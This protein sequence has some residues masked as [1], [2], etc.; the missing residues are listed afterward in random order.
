MKLK[1]PINYHG[2]Y[3]QTGITKGQVF[4]STLVKEWVSDGGEVDITIFEPPY[5]VGDKTSSG[6]VESVKIVDDNWVVEIRD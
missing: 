1:I 6:K 3:R 2:L 4:Y 5:K